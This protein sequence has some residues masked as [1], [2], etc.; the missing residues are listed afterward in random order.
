M[1][2]GCKVKNAG[3]PH[4]GG[5]AAICSLASLA[6]GIP[7]SSPSYQAA[8]R[9]RLPAKHLGGGEEEL[10]SRGPGSGI[11]IHPQVRIPN[12]QERSRLVGP[13]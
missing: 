13:F 6:A 11:A 8:F 9:A 10:P 2:S 5:G 7:L 3:N 12:S 4:L 1:G